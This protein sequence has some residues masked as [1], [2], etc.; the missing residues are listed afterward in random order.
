MDLTS[1]NSSKCQ[2]QW[3]ATQ[4]SVIMCSRDRWQCHQDPEDWGHSDLTCHPK[5]HELNILVPSLLLLGGSGTFKRWD[6]LPLVG[7]E[8]TGVMPWKACTFSP[9]FPIAVRYCETL[10]QSK[11][12]PLGGGGRGNR[13]LPH[14]FRMAWN[15]A[16]LLHPTQCWDCRHQPSHL[17]PFHP[18]SCIWVILSQQH[19]SLTQPPRR[20][21][22]LLQEG[23]MVWQVGW[24]NGFLKAMFPLL[25]S[26]VLCQTLCYRCNG[27][28]PS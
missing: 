14:S 7:N 16:I 27:S 17:L 25:C 9:L 13:D 19:K 20:V 10:N 3:S 2:R 28:Q 24:T 26:L 5:A 8:V 11:S 21:P 18:L 23:L 4:N 22:R 1:Q 15:S 12:F 6:L